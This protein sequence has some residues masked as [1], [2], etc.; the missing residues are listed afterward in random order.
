MS[1][2]IV[3]KSWNAGSVKGK[4]RS[5]VAQ[6]LNETAAD[7][8]K[9][10]QAVAP[11][12]TGFMANTIEIVDAATPSRLVV[13]WGNVTAQYT[14]W[15]EI[16]SRGRSGRYFLRHGAEVAYPGLAKRLGGSL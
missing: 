6:A 15:Q 13:M 3:I 2:G 11:R 10:A 16:G 14:L 5:K 8:V 7:A 12:D 4:V 1:V 9:A